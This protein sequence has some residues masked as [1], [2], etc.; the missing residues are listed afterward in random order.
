MAGRSSQDF[1][2]GKTGTTTRQT[3][4][5]TQKNANSTA[6]GEQL[7]PEARDFITKGPQIPEG[8]MPARAPREE[9]DT[10]MKELNK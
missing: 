5:Q 6:G 3:R 1:Q 8:D 10:R 7:R 2:A 4:S 9:I